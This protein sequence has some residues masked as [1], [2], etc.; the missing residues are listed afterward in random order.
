MLFPEGVW[1]SEGLLCAF[2]IIMHLS[3]ANPSQD[4]LGNNFVPVLGD[5]THQSNI[6]LIC[7]W[8]GG[9][10]IQIPYSYIPPVGRCIIH[11]SLNDTVE[12]PT[13]LLQRTLVMSPFMFFNAERRQMAG[14]STVFV[15]HAPVLLWNPALMLKLHA[16]FHAALTHLKVLKHILK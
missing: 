3:M 12:P 9:Y 4:D 8:C 16:Y 14:G 13:S 5:S 11:H 10:D 6:F 1:I 2:I 15:A 7:P